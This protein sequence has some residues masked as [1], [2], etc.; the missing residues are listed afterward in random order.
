MSG[1][2]MVVYD[3]S[4]DKIRRRV[5]NHLANH[6]ERVQ[7]SV[8]ECHL[9]QKELHLLRAAVAVELDTEDSVR[10]Y[11]VCKWCRKEVSWQGTGTVS[12]DPDFFQV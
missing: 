11:P 7:Y 3:I 8:F 4:D 5:A 10:W 9:T 6:G 12:N 2:W 1:L